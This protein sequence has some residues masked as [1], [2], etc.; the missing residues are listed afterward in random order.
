ML[1]LLILTGKGFFFD[2]S[3]T[4]TSEK[5]TDAANNK[6]IAIDFF[7]NYTSLSDR[8]EKIM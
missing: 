5:S 8:I 4:V 1:S 6:I 3:H 7:I 2:L